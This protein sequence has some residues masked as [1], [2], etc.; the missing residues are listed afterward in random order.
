MNAHNRHFLIPAKANT[1]WEVVS[2]SADD[3]IVRMRVSPRARQK[4]LALPEFWTAPGDPCHRRAR[5][6]T[7]AVDLAYRSPTLQTR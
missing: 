1:C 6:R 5:A 2:G 4:C 3:S 7:R